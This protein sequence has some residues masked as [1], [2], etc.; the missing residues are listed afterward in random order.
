MIKKTLTVLLILALMGGLLY[1]ASLIDSYR[2][3][4]AALAKHTVQAAEEEESWIP[5]ITE[6]EERE[7]VVVLLYGIDAGEWVND[8]FRPGPGRADTIV[9]IK[10]DLA[11]EEFSLLSIPRDTMV[12]IPG[13]SGFDKINHA[14]F[15]EGPEL[16]VKTVESFTGVA[17][18]HYIGF[19]YLAFKD[20]V[21]ILGGV[22]FE[23][24]EDI[25]SRHEDFE[26]GEQV[27]DGDEAFALVRFRSE[28]LGDIARVMR[29][30]R[31]MRAVAREAE[32]QALD[33]LLLLAIAAWKNIETD[34]SLN[35]AAIWGGLLLEL[36][37]EEITK[38]IVPGWF[39]NPNGISYW[40][41]DPEETGAVIEK[42]F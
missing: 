39:Y 10:A 29:Q 15:Y 38:E 18:D 26:A 33:Q 3:S 12:E 41:P 32:E 22:T 30:Q 17:V 4:F 2:Q 13:R 36:E 40:R 23:V 7:P 1:S 37:E 28:P 34:V 24:D 5:R 35:E 42:L 9:L 19:N 27:L 16:L 31:F 21:D 14:Y 20:V 11:A 8:K 25:A 6:E